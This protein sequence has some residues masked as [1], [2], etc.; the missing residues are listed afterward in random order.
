LHTQD[1]TPSLNATANY[2]LE[3]GDVTLQISRRLTP[4]G[5]GSLVSTNRVSLDGRYGWTERL[6][7]SFSAS[8]ISSHY[9]NQTAA[10]VRYTAFGTTLSWQ[11]D[12]Q[13]SI[14]AGVSRTEQR[15]VGGAAV[16]RANEVFAALAY[17]WDPIAMSR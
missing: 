9:P 17:R 10:D 7:Q 12:R 8:N 16:A 4:N 14:D 13:V 5:S 2:A 1:T 15:S 3:R 11:Y 6:S